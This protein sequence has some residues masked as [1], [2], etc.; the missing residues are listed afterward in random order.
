[1]ET[2]PRTPEEHRFWWQANTSVPYGYCWCGCEQPTSISR[3]SRESY[4]VKDCPRKYLNGHFKRRVSATNART[5]CAAYEQGA[6]SQE[7]ADD[8]GVSKHVILDVL[9]R[10]G[11][12]TRPSG[13]RRWHTCN[14]EFFDEIDSEMK[15]YILGFYSADG[16]I[17]RTN[18]V[19]ITLQRKDH[20][21]LEALRSAL[22]ASNPVRE[23][24]SSNGYPISC[25]HIT[26]SG[27]ARGLETHGV[28]KRKTESLQWPR[29]IDHALMRHYLRGYYDGDG[30]LSIS[31]S[32]RV[33]SDGT[34]W[35]A[36]IWSLA[37]NIGFCTS[38]QEFLMR[39][40]GLRRTKLKTFRSTSKMV[41]VEYGGPLQVARISRLLYDGA[42]IY[43][44]RKYDKAAQ[45]L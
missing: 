29:H 3:V 2:I 41:S 21:H 33:K 40:L 25:L 10:G 17:T 5:I 12:Q 34:R 20:A 1:M 18:D 19:T 9:Q 6:L 31:Q 22:E 23:Y 32:S 43:L 30:S 39:E 15:A 4:E 35:L 24:F 36:A 37:G 44:P 8:W 11:V 13:A 16:S 14:D 45:L 28:T 27:L 38:A 26:S 42:T 7:L